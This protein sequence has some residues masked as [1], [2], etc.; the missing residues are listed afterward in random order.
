MTLIEYFTN[1]HIDNIA[2]CLRLRPEKMILVGN[3]EEMGAPVKRYEKL[4]KQRGQRTEVTMCDIRG[5]DIHGICAVLRKLIQEEPD[6]LMDITGGDA[7]AILAAGAVL[8]QLEPAERQR[9]RIEKFE[10][11]TGTVLD[12][13]DGCRECGK[14]V[15][16]TVEEVISLHGGSLY[17]ESYQPPMFHTSKEIAGLWSIASEDPKA[18]N[19]GIMV[20]NELESRADSKT[21][22]FLPLEHLR[23]SVS[24]FAQKEPIVR[25]LL[26]KLSKHGIIR[27]QSSEYALEYT[28]QSP[29]LRYCTLKAGNVLEVKTLLEGREVLENGAPFFQDCQTSVGIDWDG[30]VH[31]VKE[32]IPETRNEI[33]VVL[34]RGMTPLFISCKNGDIGEEELY[35]LHTVAQRFGG[36]YAKKMLIATDLNLKNSAGNRAFIQRAWDMDVFLVTD[37]GELSREEWKDIFKK[38]IQ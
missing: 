10:Y 33:D 30:V 6:C 32:R 5:K 23:D 14:T 19:R 29:L 21:Q 26:E 3:V 25:E 37:A 22:V 36:P 17:P 20:L 11:N 9:I 13:V 24:G 7:R 8:A 34:M 12:C 16:L 27:D 4:L 35:K 38:A 15:S 2:A 1:S 28:Y 31:D 18:W